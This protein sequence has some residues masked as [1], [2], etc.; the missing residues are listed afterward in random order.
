MGH[1]QDKY[2]GA[3]V[4]LSDPANEA[5]PIVPDTPLDDAARGLYIGGAG[6]ISMKGADDADWRLWKNV[7]AGTFLPFRVAAVRAAGTTAT[8]MLALY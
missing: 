5:I 2:F 1:Q 4:Q 7:A 3:P 6:D 8:N